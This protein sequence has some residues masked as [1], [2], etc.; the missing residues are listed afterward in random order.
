M[1][2]SISNVWLL[3]IIMFFILIFAAYIAVTVDYS[4]TFKL[5]NEVLSIIEKNKGFTDA[6]GVD[7]GV[8]KIKSGENI[9]TG[10]GAAQTINVYLAAHAYTAKGYCPDD[11][12]Q[13]YGMTD[14]V[15][16]DSV[17][18]YFE[19]ASSS[20]KYYYCVSKYY[21][22]KSSDYYK[23][24]YYKIRLFYKVEFPVLQ[25]FFSVKVEGITDEIYKPVDDLFG[26][27]AVNGNYYTR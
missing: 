16:E 3:G 8:S 21:T 23:S 20:K 10:V 9:R 5:K 14:L 2:E 12:T 19:S 22:G 27:S 7:S 25:E 15:W 6:V 13:W 4:K 24:I 18:S 17:L 11:G 26:S 1:K